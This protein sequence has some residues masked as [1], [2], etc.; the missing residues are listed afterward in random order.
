MNQYDTLYYIRKECNP[1]DNCLLSL[2]CKKFNDEKYLTPFK[3]D[4][5]SKGWV[6][7]G[8]Y[9][10]QLYNFIMSNPINYNKLVLTSLKYHNYDIFIKLYKEYNYKEKK[11]RERLEKYVGMSSRKIIDFYIE[12]IDINLKYSSFYIKGLIKSKNLELLNQ[13]NSEILS[14]EYLRVE[15]V[16]GV[17]YYNI[18]ELYHMVNFNYGLLNI[19]PETLFEYMKQDNIRVNLAIKTIK[20]IKENHIP[21]LKYLISQEQIDIEH[22]KYVII[23]NKNLEIVKNIIDRINVD[24]SRPRIISIKRCIPLNVLPYVINKLYIYPNERTF[25]DYFKEYKIKDYNELVILS[26]V[27]KDMCNKKLL[28]EDILDDIM[29]NINK[30]KDNDISIIRFKQFCEILGEDYNYY[31]MPK[32]NYHNIM[33]YL[34]IGFIVVYV[35]LMIITY[36]IIFH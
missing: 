8:M 36:I 33:N 12:K 6:R 20:Q 14:I 21:D 1:F 26:D 11:A 15:F 9:T 7:Y 32:F 24:C 31:K 30:R 29:D 17:Y 23:Y 2:T 4:K 19:H 16:H 22:L 5:L 27:Y 34:V 18:K 25:I 35:I 28:Y 13:L 10:D 3:A